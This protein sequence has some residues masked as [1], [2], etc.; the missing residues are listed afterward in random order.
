MLMAKERSV[1]PRATCLGCLSC[2]TVHLEGKHVLD[3]K[4]RHVW[5]LSPSFPRRKPIK[6]ALA[7]CVVPLLRI[8]TREAQHGSPHI[9]I[10][11]A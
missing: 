2:V 11:T 10:S 4:P 3:L 5:F 6:V 8:A 7:F 9:D 1:N